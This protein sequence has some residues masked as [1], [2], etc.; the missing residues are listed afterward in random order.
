MISISKNELLNAIK[1]LSFL[2]RGADISFSEIKKFIEITQSSTYSNVVLNNN[3]ILPL[4]N[5]LV[6]D[7]L[8]KY[9]CGI[10]NECFYKLVDNDNSIEL[11]KMKLF[12][13]KT[14]IDMKI[15]ELMD[16]LNKKE[17]HI[18]KIEIKDNNFSNLNPKIISSDYEEEEEEE[19][20]NEKEVNIK[21]K[22]VFVNSQSD[23]TIKYSCNMTVGSCS[24]PHFQYRHQMCKHLK[25][26]C[27]VTKISPYLIKSKISKS[28]PGNESC[29]NIKKK[30]S[31]Y[32]SYKYSQNYA[33]CK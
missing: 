26:A 10:N 21:Q 1:T 17:D 33:A 20:N 32:N 24:C 14:D 9:K 13:L 4:L 3:T 23:P 19:I 2:K 8:L 12:M 22:I 29:K 30:P 6:T 16:D 7:K 28:S 15:S 25:I 5:D 11:L 27:D 31:K 18:N